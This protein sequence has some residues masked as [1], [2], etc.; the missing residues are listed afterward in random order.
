MKDKAEQF[1]SNKW[2][3]SRKTIETEYETILTDSQWDLLVEYLKKYDETEE[4]YAELHELI[5]DIEGLEY[6][7][8]EYKEAWLVAQGNPYPINKLGQNVEEIDE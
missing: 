2:Q 4:A 1:I 6:F 7:D 3:L 5:S 8:K